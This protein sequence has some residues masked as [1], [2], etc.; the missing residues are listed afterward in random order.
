MCISVRLCGDEL[1]RDGIT[2]DEAVAVARILEE[3]GL[4]DLINTS[5]GTA[6]QTLYMIEASMRIPP[7]YA[8]FIPRPSARRCGCR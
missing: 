6:T 8:L 1:I 7:D 2:M 5:I 3:D 4:I